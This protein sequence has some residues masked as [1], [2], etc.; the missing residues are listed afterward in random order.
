MSA[1]V[2][3]IESRF[4]RIVSESRRERGMSTRVVE[5]PFCGCHT[6]ARLW[7]L[8]GSGKRCDCGALFGWMGTATRTHVAEQSEEDQ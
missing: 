7:S 1:E 2:R 4:Y 3:R 8:A 5:C 6:E